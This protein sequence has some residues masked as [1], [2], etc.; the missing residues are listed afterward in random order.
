[1]KTRRNP[2]FFQATQGSYG[3]VAAICQQLDNAV[4]PAATGSLVLGV[5]AALLQISLTADY[6]V[7][8]GL[9]L[10]LVEW[11]ANWLESVRQ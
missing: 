10:H 7:A 9:L 5:V 8:T 4:A 6:M 2:Q 11:F 3:W 1:V